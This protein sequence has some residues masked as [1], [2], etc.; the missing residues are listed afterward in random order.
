VVIHSS[1]LRRGTLE[2]RVETSIGNNGNS[3]PDAAGVF[4][5]LRPARTLRF[6]SQW[7]RP[8]LK[9]NPR[10]TEERTGPTTDVTSLANVRRLV[11]K[12]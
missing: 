7:N 1:G 2:S 5:D 12:R 4:A 3:G 11:G 8:R 6:V 9:L 10:G